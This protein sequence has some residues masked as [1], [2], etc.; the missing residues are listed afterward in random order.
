MAYSDPPAP[1]FIHVPTHAFYVLLAGPIIGMVAI[2]FIWAGQLSDLRGRLKDNDISRARMLE[3]M[4]E[5][6]ISPATTPKPKPPVPEF[7]P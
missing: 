2:S 3:V 7:R 4:Y 5:N 1:G 6:G